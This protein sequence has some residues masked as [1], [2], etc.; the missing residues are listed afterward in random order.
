M[1]SH[2]ATMRETAAA[3]W[4]TAKPIAIGLAIGLVAGPFISSF[5]GFQVR[6]STA[7]TAARAGIVEQQAM[8]CAERARAA[9]PST[10]SLDWQG[11]SE[12]ARKWA[13]M[14]GSTIADS[15]VVYACSGKLS[16]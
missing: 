2:T 5:A 6:T 15:E 11:R 12:L 16:T 9:V 7:Q 3:K 10:A 13:T 4:A 1:S 8:F 14:P